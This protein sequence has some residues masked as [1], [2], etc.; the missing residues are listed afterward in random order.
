MLPF[1]IDKSSVRGCNAFWHQLA[2]DRQEQEV[3]FVVERALI[4]EPQV[5]KSVLLSF[6]VKLS[7]TDLYAESRG[8]IVANGRT[9]PPE[10]FIKEEVVGE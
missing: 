6:L 4:F 1:S 9:Q 2:V 8:M 10:A 7:P 3:G 5:E